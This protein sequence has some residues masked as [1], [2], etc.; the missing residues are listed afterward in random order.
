MRRITDLKLN[1]IKNVYINYDKQ[2]L[3]EISWREFLNN[4]IQ[5]KIDLTDLN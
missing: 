2:N 4:V 1:E 5:L 3:N